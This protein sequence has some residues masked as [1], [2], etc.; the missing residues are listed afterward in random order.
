MNASNYLPL[1]DE[2]AAQLSF[3]PD[4]PEETADSTLRALWFTAAGMPRSA[5]AAMAGDLPALA[6]AQ[7]QGLRELLDRRLAGVPLAHLTGRQ[8]FLGLEMLAGA[9]ALVPRKETEL[10]ARTAIAAVQSLAT[11]GHK[12]LVVDVCSG[13]GN[14][15]LA[16]AQAVP[17]AQVHGADLSDA[18]VHLAIRNADHL[19]LSGVDFR[20]GDLLAPFDEA[21]FIGRI[22][23]LTCN[24]PY[25][26]RAKVERMPAEIAAH[27]PRLAFDGGALGISILMRLLDEAPRFLAPRGWLIFEV[28]AGQGAGLL[29]RLAASGAFVEIV[30]A[31]DEAGVIRVIAARR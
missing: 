22:D 11:A 31:E 9:D 1:R 24:P 17:G 2:L 16:V 19:G 13:S 5:Q 30:P 7:R 14:V 4:K 20:A 23:V 3:L 10:L 21:G 18:A 6:E 29:K 12:P 28:G 15:A 27:E 8:Q 26:N 25:I